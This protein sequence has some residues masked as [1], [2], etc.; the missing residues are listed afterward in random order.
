MAV[1]PIKFVFGLPTYKCPIFAHRIDDRRKQSLPLSKKV[2]YTS[3]NQ[4]LIPT[5]VFQVCCLKEYGACTFVFHHCI[6]HMDFSPSFFLTTC[7]FFSC[8]PSQTNSFCKLMISAPL[9]FHI[10]LLQTA[11]QTLSAFFT[12]AVL[13]H[14]QI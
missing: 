11:S 12:P 9:L 5:L 2:Q 13:N 3:L 7:L 1:S 4:N 10:T 8:L 14:K 6:S